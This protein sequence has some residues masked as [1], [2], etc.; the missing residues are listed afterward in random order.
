MVGDRGVTLSGGQK[1][2]ISIARALLLEP[3][4][5]ILDDSLSAVDAKTEKKILESL[6]KM[7]VQKTTFIS[8]HRLSAVEKADLIIVLKD[9][10][11]TEQGSHPELMA[12]KG[13]YAATY[14]RQQLESLLADGEEH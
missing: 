4:I 10:Q 6:G 12:L 1:Q 7:R 11:I 3:E 13:W 2:R 9:G 8:S 5:L 14:R